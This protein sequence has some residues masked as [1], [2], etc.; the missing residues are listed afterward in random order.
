M[1]TWE[2]LGKHLLRVEGDVVLARAQGTISGA[3]IVQLLDR[4]LQ[5]ERQY[6]HVFELVDA[7][8]GGSMDAEARRINGDWHKQHR[9]HI[10]CAVFGA[11]RLVQTLVTLM[12]N[13]FRL[14]GREQVHIHFAASEDE[15]WAWV[16]QRRSELAPSRSRRPG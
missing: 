4:M 3:E 7:R 8:N 13:A 9:I 6:G 15:A 11:S 10:E 1:D 12:G 14:L 5:V 16:T 2:P